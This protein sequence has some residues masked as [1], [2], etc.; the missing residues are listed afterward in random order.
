MNEIEN[1]LTLV[2]NNRILKMLADNGKIVWPVM[3]NNSKGI[4]FK[5]V[6]EIDSVGSQ[7]EHKGIQYKLK[8][9]P[10]CFYPYLY[11]VSH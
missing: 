6:D 11:Q 8:Y 4:K 5:Y 10:G 3:T 1:N 9:R 2:D 7:F